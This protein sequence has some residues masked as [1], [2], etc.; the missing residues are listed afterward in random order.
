MPITTHELK[1]IQSKLNDPNQSTIFIE[2]ILSGNSSKSDESYQLVQ[3]IIKTSYLL[4][5]ERAKKLGSSFARAQMV[6]NSD[7]HAMNVAPIIAKIREDG[8]ET[9]QGIADALNDQGIT[10]RSGHRWYA[11]TV[12]LIVQRIELLERQGIY[13]VDSQTQQLIDTVKQL[14]ET[15]VTSYRGISDALNER[16]I[17]T[18]QGYDWHPASAKSLIRDV[19]AIIK[20]QDRV[21]SLM[22]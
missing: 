20:L 3:S 4:G 9:F 18:R 7:T 12:R 11:G 2:Q 15:G 10:T 5:L 1:D 16:G 14:Q 21:K 22:R 17:K 19:E 13:Q 8:I 6:I